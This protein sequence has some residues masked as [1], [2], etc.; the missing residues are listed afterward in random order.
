VSDRRRQLGAFGEQAAADHLVRH[1]HH[2]LARRWRCRLGEI[3]LITQDGA[4]LVF[5]EVRTR[6]A[7]P[8]GAAEESVGPAKRER[9]ARL[10]YTYLAA[11]GDERPW[12]I[13]VVAVDLDAR[14]RVTRI[15][16]IPHAVGE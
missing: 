8:P 13:D 12:R 15:A 14:G 16:H 9:L 6:R 2:I 11:A 7:G 1:G 10:A 3:D 5:V 4:E